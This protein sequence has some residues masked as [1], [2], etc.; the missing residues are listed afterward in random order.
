MITPESLLDE[1]VHARIEPVVNF[2][3]RHAGGDLVEGEGKGNGPI[4]NN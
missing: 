1:A 3:V 4:K 2:L